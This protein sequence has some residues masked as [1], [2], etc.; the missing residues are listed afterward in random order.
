MFRPFVLALSL[1]AL[2][3]L[4]DVHPV[5][6]DDSTT[7]DGGAEPVL[8]CDSQESCDAC[9]QCATQSTC[10]AALSA[11]QNDASCVGLDQCYAMCGSDG[12]CKSQCEYANPVGVS[13]YYA[14]KG[15]MYCTA[16]PKKCAGY[17]ACQ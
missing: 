9:V 14:A 16:C 11:C 1:V 12:E 8:T 13:P 10:A 17:M 6:S 7:G 4:C 3:P 2:D 5:S 15:C